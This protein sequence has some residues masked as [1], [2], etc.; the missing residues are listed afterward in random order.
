MA[1]RKRSKS[2][3]KAAASRSY[4]PPSYEPRPLRSGARLPWGAISLALATV[5]VVLAWWVWQPSY[6]HS[7]VPEKL[8]VEV[9]QRYPH[10][11]AAWT[12]GLLWHDGHVYEGTGQKGRSSLRRVDLKT[13]AVLEQTDLPASVFGEGLAL[14]GEKLIQLTWKEQ[15]AFVWDLKTFKSQREF[16]YAGE[17]WGLCFDGKRLVMSDGTERL[18]FR[19]PETFEEV[20]HVYVHEAGNRFTGRLNELECAGGFVYANVWTADEDRIVKIDPKTGNVVANIDASGLLAAGETRGIDVLN[21]IAYV[22]ERDTFLITG[23]LWPKMFE[24]RF[25][26]AR[27]ASKARAP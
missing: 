7:V 17:G 21:G 12:Q 9:I 3:A 1:K 20:G 24:V 8:R 11:V 22:P 10:D 26:P 23:K 27:A 5:A 13:G 14:A 18:A 2:P 19:S 25:V 4:D 6:A 15:R 16:K